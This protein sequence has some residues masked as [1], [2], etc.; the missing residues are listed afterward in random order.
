[1]CGPTLIRTLSWKLNI[2]KEKTPS[3]HAYASNS[4]TWKLLI[5][6]YILSSIPGICMVEGKNQ[7]NNGRRL[8][9]SSRLSLAT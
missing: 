8:S 3:V 2:K 9:I 5:K 7:A 1:M 4:N 6:P